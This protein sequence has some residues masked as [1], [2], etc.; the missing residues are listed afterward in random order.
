MTSASIR[1]YDKISNL[2]FERTKTVFYSNINGD[3][4]DI[5]DVADYLKRQMTSPV[6]FDKQMES[7]SRDGFDS[8][9]EFGPGK[10]LCGFI[11]RG[12]KGASSLNVED[13]KT[14]QKCLEALST[15]NVT[16]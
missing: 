14:V 3:K 8:F 7:M 6:R 12:I 16:A 11:R 10:T 1:F 4:E 9:V 5:S 15:R 13:L 2:A